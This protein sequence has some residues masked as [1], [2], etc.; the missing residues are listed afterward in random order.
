M[1]LFSGACHT[2][3]L[4]TS[5]NWFRQ[6]LGAVRQ[7][8]ITWGNV[9][10]DP[11]RHLVSLGPKDWKENAFVVDVFVF[12]GGNV[13]C[14]VSILLEIFIVICHNT[15]AGTYIVN[16][17]SINIPDESRNLFLYVDYIFRWWISIRNTRWSWDPLIFV[18]E[19]N[20]I[21]I[22]LKIYL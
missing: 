19:Y 22:R 14:I 16:K 12:Q 4:M 15:R 21:V 7:H 6:W 2:T 10:P 20:G 17:W 13:P 18:L 11:C 5:W 9:D 3:S 8:A 1:K